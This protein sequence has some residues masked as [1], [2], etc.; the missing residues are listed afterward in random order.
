MEVYTVP[1]E[2]FT[3]IYKICFSEISLGGD[4]RF[5][6]WLNQEQIKMTYMARYV[7][8]FQVFR[9]L[10]KPSTLPWVCRTDVK[11]KGILLT[12]PPVIS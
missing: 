8:Q 12:S 2:I 5:I 7:R 1:V 4:G 11:K 10:S 9:N 3:V 6:P